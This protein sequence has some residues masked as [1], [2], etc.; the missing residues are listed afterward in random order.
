MIR[1]MMFDF[2]NVLMHFDT[3]RFYDFV[4]AHQQPGS[5]SPTDFFWSDCCVKY[6]LGQIN[7]FE[8][9]E[10]AKHALGLEAGIEEFF[11]EFV[12][13]MKPD[14]RMLELKHVLRQNGI[15]L[16][17]VSNTNQYHFEYVRQ[18]WPEV[19]MNFDHL[20]LSFQLGVRKPEPRIWQIS[21]R[22]LKIS[23]NECFFIDDLEVNTC[24]F[25]RLGGIGHHY[26]ITDEHFCPNGRLEIER[27]RL[28]L[29]M[30]N[31][32]MLNESQAGKLMRINF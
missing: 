9:F 10:S 7:S 1:C 11:F 6:E 21:A 26:Q 3:Q 14:L 25:K 5:A 13:L 32:G 24:E 22:R 15:K 29:R 4:R 23:L 30:V 27:K 19:F 8:F 28:I 18:K 17:V 2:G 16:A 20:A 31:L 12:D